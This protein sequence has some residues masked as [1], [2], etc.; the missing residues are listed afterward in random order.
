MIDI[1]GLDSSQNETNCMEF[2]KLN[3]KSE[4]H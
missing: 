4:L 1:L 3:N 2:K